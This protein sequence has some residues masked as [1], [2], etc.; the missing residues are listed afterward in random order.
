M[1]KFITILTALIT[2]VTAYSVH[3]ENYHGI[4]IDDIFAQSDWESKDKI[5]QYIDDY[6]AVLQYKSEL[7]NCA[8]ADISQSADCLDK[9]TETVIYRFYTYPQQSFKNYQNFVHSTF[10]AYGVYHCLFK[11]SPGGSDCSKEN[12]AHSL[13]I[14]TD[15]TNSLIEKAETY[16]TQYDFIAENYKE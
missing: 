12:Y 8:Q 5:K 11:Y 15:Y 3:A 10:E 1:Q 13:R 2:T 16:L 7:K 6:R 14:I 4:D 9:V